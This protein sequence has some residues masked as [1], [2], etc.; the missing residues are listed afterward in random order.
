MENGTKIDI[1][2]YFKYIQ[3]IKSNINDEIL[4]VDLHEI[5]MFYTNDQGVKDKEQELYSDITLIYRLRNLIA[6]NAVYPQYLINLYANKA[7]H[8][9]CRM[10]RYLIDK[11]RIS[12]DSLE[13][14]LIDTSSKYD[15]FML[16]ITNEIERLKH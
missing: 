16:N 14:I 15:E 1:S 4:K 2:R 9:S 5:E 10:I 11:S 8:I 13:E 7:Q 12:N 3:D 6:H